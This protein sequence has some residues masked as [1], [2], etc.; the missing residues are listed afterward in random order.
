MREGRISHNHHL[1][2]REPRTAPLYYSP[3][4]QKLSRTFWKADEEGIRE[5]RAL[6]T[7]HPVV[8]AFDEEELAGYRTDGPTRDGYD[9]VTVAKRITF[10]VIC[11]RV[12]PGTSSF[13]TDSDHYDLATGT[14]TRDGL[15]AVCTPELPTT[16]RRHRRCDCGY[17]ESKH[18][19][20]ANGTRTRSGLT[21]LRK[22]FN[23]GEASESC[24]ETLLLEDS[25]SHRVSYR[26]MC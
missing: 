7:A 22:R 10:T 15:K 1:L 26:S 8:A 14:D 21:E 13:C 9:A 19:R 25:R 16:P 23:S 20:S 4:S 11:H 6:L 17:C 2:G 18:R 24:D 12:V 3:L 5:H